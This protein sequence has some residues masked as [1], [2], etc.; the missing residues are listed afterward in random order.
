MYKIY[1]DDIRIPMDKDWIL[2]KNYDE[3]VNMVTELGLNNID[4][5]SLDHDLGDTAMDEYHNNV[6]YNNRIDYS[7]I[8]EK[9]GL[10][11][12][13][14][15]VDFFYD[16][17]P[18][19]SSLDNIHKKINKINF[20]IVYTHSANPIG[21]ENIINYINNFLKFEQQPETCNKVI[22]GFSLT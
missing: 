22:I 8:K 21:S 3:F 4:I 20:P 13:K 16:Q 17:N 18:K 15:L 14:W 7:K 2:V 11:C 10:D 5:I 12:A 1:L 6:V 9:T 19:R